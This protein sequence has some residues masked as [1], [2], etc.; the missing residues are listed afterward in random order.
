MKIGQCA[1]Q[2]VTICTY[3]GPF[4]FP[5]ECQASFEMTKVC[6]TSDVRASHPLN[7]ALRMQ[8]ALTHTHTFSVLRSWSMLPTF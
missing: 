4:A 2:P 7:W 1:D 5:V 6:G 8:R 3:I